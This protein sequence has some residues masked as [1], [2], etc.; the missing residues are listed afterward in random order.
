ME[1][2]DLNPV[3]CSSSAMCNQCVMCVSVPGLRSRCA[4]GLFNLTCVSEPYNHI[5][6]VLK[7]LVGVSSSSSLEV[8]MVSFGG[9]YVSID[10][11]PNRELIVAFGKKPL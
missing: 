3:S 11:N 10:K 5:E 8:S 1:M 9:Q 6:R 2:L 7:A 4:Q